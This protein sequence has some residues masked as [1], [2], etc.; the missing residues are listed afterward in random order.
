MRRTPDGRFVSALDVVRKLAGVHNAGS[1]WWILQR[2]YQL[3][4][5]TYKF[6]GAG[7]RKTPVVDVDNTLMRMV[8]VMRGP[9]AEAVRAAI[10]RGPLAC[11]GVIDWL[12]RECA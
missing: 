3:P 11:G 1:A 12:N 2:T 7:Q 5:R 6:P 8:V 9:A 10:M 4:Y